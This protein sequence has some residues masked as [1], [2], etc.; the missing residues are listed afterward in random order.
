MNQMMGIFLIMLGFVL[1]PVGVGGI[2]I[3]IGFI[4]FFSDNKKS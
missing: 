3:A 1:L 2:V 4:Y